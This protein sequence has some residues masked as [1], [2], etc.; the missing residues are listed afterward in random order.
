MIKAIKD[1][2]G[3]F[4]D[5][6]VGH[7]TWDDYSEMLRVYKVYNF[8]FFNNKELKSAHMTFSSYPGTISST[9]DFYVMNGALVITETTLEILNENSYSLVARDDKYVPDYMRIIINNRLAHTAADWVK[10]LKF[11]NTGTYNS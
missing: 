9:D 1:D 2:N 7:S 10:W 6:Y 11:V 8:E 3:N 5:L 4:K